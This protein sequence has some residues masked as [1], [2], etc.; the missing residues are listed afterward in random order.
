MDIDMDIDMDMD[1]DISLYILTSSC[2]ISEFK[3][4]TFS[5]LGFLGRLSAGRQLRRL[6]TSALD[7]FSLDD[8]QEKNALQVWQPFQNLPPF[9]LGFGVRSK[10]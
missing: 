8:D 6:R 3:I 10:K 4:S 9:G 5:P 7:F 2:L 1:M